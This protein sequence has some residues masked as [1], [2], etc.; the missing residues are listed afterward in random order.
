[1]WERGFVL[2]PLAELA[3]EL[4]RARLGRLP[5]RFEGVR[6]QGRL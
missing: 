4:V 5:P 1:M 3:P 2:A 6:P